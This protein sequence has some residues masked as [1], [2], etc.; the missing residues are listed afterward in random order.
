MN[1][2]KYKSLSRFDYFLDLLIKKRL[3]GATFTELNDPMEGYFVS[4]NFTE[5]EWEQMKQTKKQVRICSLSRNYNNALMW[6]HYA[7]EHKGCCIELEVPDS[8][9]IHLDVQYKPLMPKL[10]SGI[11]R[12]EAVRTIF[13][14][15]SDFW[16]Y[17]DEVR[18]I[19]IVPTSKD[20]KPYKADLP[21]RIKKIYLGVRVANEDKERIER[22][23]NALDYQ[24]AVEKLKRNEIIF[25]R[26]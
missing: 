4:E 15:K 26:G 18:F 16:S 12:E 22:V 6:A 17:E 2:Y 11:D 9:W 8:T 25:W 1:L 20:G 14:C 7:D 21:I 23:V 13:G 24:I 3:H 19:K 10:I 5:T